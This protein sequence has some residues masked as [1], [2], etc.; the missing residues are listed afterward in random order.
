MREADLDYRT[1][2]DRNYGIFTEDEQE[3]IRRTRILILGDTGSGETIC[4]ALARCGFERIAVAGEDRYVPSDTNRQIG[5]FSDTIGRSKIEVMAETVR[6][7]NPRAEVTLHARIPSEEELPAMIGG[8]DIVIPAVDDLAYSTLVFRTCRVMGRP[9]VLCL[10]AGSMGWVSVF[11]PESAT[12]EQAFGIPRLDYRGLKGVIHSKEYRCAQYH[13]ITQGD[14]RV[15]WFSGYFS[16]RRPLALLCATEWT[17]I[18]LATLETMKIA[19]GKWAPIL[20]PRCW[21]LKNGRLKVAR[22]SWFA[23]LHRKVGWF[24]FGSPE[25][26]RRHR[27]THYIWKK[28]FE[29]L[30]SRQRR[31]GSKP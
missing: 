14:W 13:Y 15:D 28:V 6:A 23:R 10:P 12:I 9:A 5:C 27:F 2:F 29:Y 17:L 16:G 18:S 24:V 3:R 19:S 8:A 30:E 7:I 1:L 20:A 21:L 4:S 11:S 31:D 25:G 22:F 26:L